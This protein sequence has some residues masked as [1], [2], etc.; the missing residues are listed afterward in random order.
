MQKLTAHSERRNIITGFFGIAFI[1]LSILFFASCK[2]DGG[3]Q[4]EEIKIQDSYFRISN[5]DFDGAA[6]YSKIIR[7][8]METLATEGNGPKQYTGREPLYWNNWTNEYRIKWCNELVFLYDYFP[9]W[10]CAVCKEA[11][12]CVSTPV[13]WGDIWIEGNTLNFQILTESNVEKYQIHYSD[14]GKTYRVIG[15]LKPKGPSLY[16]FTIK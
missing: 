1:V 10:F 11:A 16:S 2:K 14:D 4:K 5:L 8:T 12:P 13:E 6:S 9:T 7:T 3:M 15:E